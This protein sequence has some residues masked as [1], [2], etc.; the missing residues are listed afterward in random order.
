MYK[1]KQVKGVRNTHE[2][3][4]DYFASIFSR[5]EKVVE[6]SKTSNNLICSNDVTFFKKEVSEE[7]STLK[8]GLKS[9]DKM[10]PDL[11]HQNSCIIPDKPYFNQF[12]LFD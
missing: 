11:L 12:Q 5:D 9:F 4:N 6:V 8:L 3:F 7:I 2:A 1:G 10:S